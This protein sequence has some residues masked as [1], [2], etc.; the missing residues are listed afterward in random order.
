MDELN[1]HAFCVMQQ[2]LMYKLIGY[3]VGWEVHTSA[4][5]FSM[6]FYNY[7]GQNL[8]NNSRPLLLIDHFLFSHNFY[9]D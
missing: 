3:F 7:D 1:V 5:V 9:F 4:H 8:L 2:A 6:L